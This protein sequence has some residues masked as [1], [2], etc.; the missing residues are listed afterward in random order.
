MQHAW[1]DVKIMKVKM[2]RSLESATDA[3][4]TMARVRRASTNQPN[5]IIVELKSRTRESLVIKKLV[6]PVHNAVQILRYL[7]DAKAPRRAVQVARDLSINNSTCFNILRTLVMEGVVD[8]NPAEKAYSIGLGMVRLLRNTLVD[9]QHLSAV[10]PILREVAERY[11]VTATLWRR[12]GSD[13][14]VLLGV[15]HSN[16]TLRIHMSEGQHLPMMLGATGR[17]VGAFGGLNKSE[18]RTA[19]SQAR[20]DQPLSFDAFWTQV[21][22][23][24]KRG[25]AIDDGYFSR[26][27]LI[28]AAPI[29][30]TSDSLLYSLSTVM[31]RGQYSAQSLARLG[32]SLVRFAG[33][34]SKVF[35]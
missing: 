24:A 27:I 13:R 8:F 21:Q 14:I 6:K 11:N 25:W 3:K 5:K 4:K 26:G 32:S 28:L 19:F 17:L 18:V 2:A 29:L 23:A 9:R 12:L 22:E 15:E 7:S 16:S 35:S 10:R 31:F 33:Q 34:I 20:W 1:K 30:D